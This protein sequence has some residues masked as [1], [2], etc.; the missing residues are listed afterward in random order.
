VIGPKVEQPTARDEREAYE[1]VEL[2]DGGVCQKCR[3]SDYGINRD[4]RKG[5]GVGGRTEVQNL[6]LL[7]GSGTTGCHGWRTSHPDDAARD[8]Y[9]VPG[10]ADPADYPARRWVRTN[11]GTVRIAQVLYLPADQWGDGPGFVEIGEMEAATRRAG[12]W[13]PEVTE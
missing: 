2:R 5:R 3:R 9:A 7:C 4:H 10:W 1:L 6:Q 8:G 11:I 12:L 13:R